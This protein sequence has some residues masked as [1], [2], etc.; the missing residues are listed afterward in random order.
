M[1][2]V[3]SEF[4]AKEFASDVPE[5]RDLGGVGEGASGSASASC[6]GPGLSPVTLLCSVGGWV[7][8]APRIRAFPSAASFLKHRGEF[9]SSVRL[10]WRQSSPGPPSSCPAGPGAEGVSPKPCFP[11]QSGTAAP[12]NL[13]SSVS[14]PQV[15]LCMGDDSVWGRSDSSHLCPRRPALQ[16]WEEKQPIPAGT[17]GFRS[18]PVCCPFCG[19]RMKEQKGLEFWQQT[20]L[21]GPI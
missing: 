4:G 8:L 15:L 13:I 5:P 19:G 3:K 2:G 16:P 11:R 14:H 17:W 6:S 7:S 10:G 20:Q 9:A 1:S 21:V 18:Q 12:E